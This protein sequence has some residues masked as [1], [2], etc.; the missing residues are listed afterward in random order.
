MNSLLHPLISHYLIFRN[1]T[2]IAYKSFPINEYL[3][4]IYLSLTQQDHFSVEKMLH[5]FLGKD[6]L[7]FPI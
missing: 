4:L 7:L 6:N 2:P 3:E 1:K 5:I